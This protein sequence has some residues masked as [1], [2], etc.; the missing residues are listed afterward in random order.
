[1]SESSDTPAKR[2]SLAD[3]AR[4][5][6]VSTMTVSR[7][8]RNHPK[9][10]AETRDKVVAAAE[11]AG[12]RL[13]P[14]IGQLMQHLR[15][16]RTRPTGE[17]LAM[18]WPDVTPDER[19]GSPFL[20]AIA[21][22]A[23]GRAE[24]L[25]FSF[26]EHYLKEPGMSAARLDRILY[27][28]GVTCLIFGQVVHR[29]HGHLRMKW[30][31]YSVVNIGLGLWKPEFHRVQFHHYEGMMQAMRWLK[32]H[33]RK[34]I[35]CVIEPRT[36]ERM[37]KAWQAA[38]LVSHPLGVVQA[39]ELLLVTGE[40]TPRRLTDW[41]AEMKPDAV[42]GEFKSAKSAG[43]VLPPGL[44]YFS[45]NRVPGKSGPPGL[46][47]S[48]TLVGVG[49]VDLVSAHFNRNERG[50]PAAPKILMVRGSV[51]AEETQVAAL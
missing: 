4:A 27:A 25:G 12:Y 18:V 29:S 49:A 15:S 11:A 50:V 14:K 44:V 41:L 23:K 2:P 37:F 5:C 22:G 35:A 24:A 46:D 51:V 33:G 39:S 9:V 16:V 38:F 30:D 36:N 8:L 7:A 47:Q 43:I 31:R 19:E 3:L 13:D 34:R 48:N 42:M 10:A 6:G 26:S 45:L 40:Y 1:M 32:Q 21:Q 20:S 28:S 17:P